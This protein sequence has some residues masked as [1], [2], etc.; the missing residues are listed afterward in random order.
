MGAGGTGATLLLGHAET[1][2]DDR[3][4]ERVLGDHGDGSG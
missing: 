4:E 3:R 1:V 2:L